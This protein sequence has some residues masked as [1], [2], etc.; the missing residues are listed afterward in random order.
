MSLVTR[1]R[2]STSRVTCVNVI[3]LGAQRRQAAHW[4][5]AYQHPARYRRARRAS[6]YVIVLIH[7]ILHLSR[8]YVRHK[9]FPC[10]TSHICHAIAELAE[11]VGISLY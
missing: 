9:S 11:P 1:T 2:I 5:N 4:R 10:V 6:R 7:I 3:K 8:L